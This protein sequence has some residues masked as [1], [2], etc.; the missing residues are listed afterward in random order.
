MTGQ[1]LFDSVWMGKS[2]LQDTGINTDHDPFAI[3][4]VNDCIAIAVDLFLRFFFLPI[5][6]DIFIK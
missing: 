6:D 4:L 2:D 1:D 5:D 3:D